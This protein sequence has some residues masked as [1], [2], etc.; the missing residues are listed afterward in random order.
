M[1][2]SIT[3]GVVFSILFFTCISKEEE[4]YVFFLHNRFLETNSLKTPHPEYGKTE[5]LN[6]LNTFKAEG[7]TVISEQRVGNFKEVELATGLGHGFLFKPLHVWIQ[8]T[9][10][11]AKGNYK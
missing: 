10:K 5:Y 9:V 7:F 2:S 3:I 11:W 6:I 4:R 8:P 1:K